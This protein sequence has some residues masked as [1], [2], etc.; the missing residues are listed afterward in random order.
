MSQPQLMVST[1]TS[2]K[3]D[4]LW[5]ADSL[6]RLNDFLAYPKELGGNHLELVMALLCGVQSQLTAVVPSAGM[7]P[8]ICVEDEDVATTSTNESNLGG[9]E[10]APGHPLRC[11]AQF[12][13][14]AKAELAVRIGTLRHGGKKGRKPKR[15][16]SLINLQCKCPMA[17]SLFFWLTLAEGNI[18][19]GQS[20]RCKVGRSIKCSGYA[21]P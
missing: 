2:W 10:G 11:H 20:L 14:K 12:G 7:N 19:L 5:V 1:G 9:G 21:L 16:K 8:S 17:M 6:G 13:F 15:R 4:Y 3:I 18:S